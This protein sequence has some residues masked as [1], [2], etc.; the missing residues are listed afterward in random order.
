M[1]RYFLNIFFAGVLLSVVPLQAESQAFTQA[2]QNFYQKNYNQALANLGQTSVQ[3]SPEKPALASAIYIQQQN[4]VLARQS[5]QQF[6]AKDE[7]F[8]DYKEL[9]K[10]RI[11]LLE[12]KNWDPTFW[13]E[14]LWAFSNS[15]L[16][17]LSLLDITEYYINQNRFDDASIILKRLLSYQKDRVIRPKTLGLQIQIELERQNVLPILKLYAEMI[18]LDSTA[19]ADGRL[20][21]KIQYR[22][23]LKGSFIQCFIAPQEIVPYLRQLEEENN[24]VELEKRATEALMRFPESTQT[25]DFYYFLGVAAYGQN[26][27]KTAARYLDTATATNKN[28]AK[29]N[30]YNFAKAQT[31]I[32]MNDRKALR[33]LNE[34]VSQKKPNPY[35]KQALYWICRYT[36]QTG[37]EALY[38]TYKNRLLALTDSSSP[39]IQAL[40]WE[41]NW[42][43]ET[44]KQNEA[45][46]DTSKDFKLTNL[47]KNAV[48]SAKILG[49]YSKESG[50]LKDNMVQYPLSF[51]SY[52]ILES[53]FT[54]RPYPDR[55]S[56]LIQKY[57]TLTNMGLGSVAIMEAKY[58]KQFETKSEDSKQDYVY[59]L[60]HL[61]LRQSS[62][63]DSLKT[64]RS[65]LPES[66]IYGFLPGFIVKIFY[67]RAYWN[68]IQTYSRLY[69]VDPY[70]VL[71]IM[72]EESQFNVHAISKTDA[73][74]LMQIMPTTAKDV[75]FKLGIRW[76]GTAM[77]DHPETNIKLA[78]YY[79]SWLQTLF[80]GP[81]HYTIAAYNAGPEM[82]NTW[83]KSFGTNDMNQFV[84]KIPYSETQNY[85][86]RV[87]ETYMIYKVLYEQH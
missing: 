47:V 57:T 83:I 46:P 51:F 34:L 28:K 64:I 7:D 20:W 6:Q 49:F 50:A 85:I 15:F 36:K 52:S 81:K 48:V 70:L 59:A 68:E 24:Y 58:F 72:R 41:E 63:S 66:N 33:P 31:Y 11:A 42:V 38:F 56:R 18:Q 8:K 44:I 23:G 2:V 67:P 37:Q 14:N 71:A 74:G 62:V 35:Q 29:L 40:N 55:A 77:L 5:L 79:I 53:F 9:L 75:C 19:D 84:S 3:E 65:I 76:T 21:K 25:S 10:L 30:L 61:K 13:D 16:T 80:K 86:Q 78:T 4:P 45:T 69:K 1:T 26:Q 43:R 32:G 27:F 87:T 17:R 73:R 22:F 39:E 54:N 60:L 12:K 82:A